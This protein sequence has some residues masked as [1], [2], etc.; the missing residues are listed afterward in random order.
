ME[1]GGEQQG[2]ADRRNCFEMRSTSKCPA[3]QAYGLFLQSFSLTPHC[4]ST[5]KKKIFIIESPLF[6]PSFYS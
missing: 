5:L 4:P 1:G 2:K 6:V 3:V